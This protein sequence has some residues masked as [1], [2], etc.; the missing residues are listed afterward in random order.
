MIFRSTSTTALTR[1]PKRPSAKTLRSAKEIGP[2]TIIMGYIYHRWPQIKKRSTVRCF[3][4]KLSGDLPGSAAKKG[5]EF[6][7]AEEFDPHVIFDCL[8]AFVTG[9]DRLGLK[10]NRALDELIIGR[11]LKDNIERRRL[12]REQK[13][14]LLREKVDELADF[15]LI[16]KSQS[17]QDV[18]IFLNDVR[19]EADCD[20]SIFPEI[21]DLA[22]LSSEKRGDKHVRVDDDSH[23]RFFRDSA[24]AL[25]ISPGGTP[26]GGAF[27]PIRL[28][29]PS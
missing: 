25:L 13:L 21:D 14:M 15:R 11:I 8:Q 26:G 29:S 27:P 16:F 18:H 9:D 20:L 17:P 22:W 24:T 4:L 10:G 3:P 19:G 5:K 2:S 1:F 7:R 12:C 6:S 23:P 28:Q